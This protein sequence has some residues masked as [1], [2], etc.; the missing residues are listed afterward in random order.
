MVMALS[1]T[2]ITHVQPAQ[3]AILLTGGGGGS[4]DEMCPKITYTVH[5]ELQNTNTHPH[6]RENERERE[7][8]AQHCIYT[9]CCATL[10]DC[11]CSILYQVVSRRQ[12]TS[13]S[14]SHR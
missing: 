9:A 8:A 11:Y 1:A 14:R 3:L 13:S 4:S 7:R 6:A 2:H 5:K 10:T 12:R